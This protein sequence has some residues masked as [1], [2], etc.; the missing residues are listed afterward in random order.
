[1]IFY[2]T[3][4]LLLNFSPSAMKGEFNNQKS[5]VSVQYNSAPVNL[6]LFPRDSQ[7][8]GT[9]KIS[10]NI[11]TSGYDSL[12]LEIHSNNIMQRRQ[13]QY[14]VYNNN[15]A[16]FIFKPKIHAEL[17]EYKFIIFIKNT[18]VTDT[19]SKFD[20]VVC[21]DVYLI[22]G[23]SNSH[24]I[25]PLASY[26]NEFCRSF[27][28]NTNTTVYN[29]ADTLWGLARGYDAV[30][31]HT[32]VWGIK[33]QQLIKENYN[34][35]I[36]IIN[37]G[38]GGSTIEYNLR[39]NSNH[40]DLNTTYG[41]LLYRT[42]KAKVVY[43]VK[44]ML[45]YQGESNTDIT[46]QNYQNNFNQLYNSWK[47]D[48]PGINKFYVFQVRMGCGSTLYQQQLRNVQRTFSNIYPDVCLMATT[49]V[50]GHDGCHYNFNGYN[51]IAG[52]IF[53]LISRDFY[54]STDTANINPPAIKSAYFTSQQ[55]NR[56]A[57]VFSGNVTL[58]WG[59]D[60]SGQSLLNY[61]YFDGAYGNVNS[62]S[63]S[64]D[65]LYLNLTNPGYASKVTYLPNIYYNGTTTLY[66][67]PW[68]KNA[69][70]VGALS[71]FE[72][73]VTTYVEVKNSNTK[74]YN[75][76]LYQN[77]PNP[78]NGTTKIK[79]DIPEIKET[80]II[81]AKIIIFD[82]NGRELQVLVDKKFNPGTY[83]AFWNSTNFSSG[84]YFFKLSAGNFNSVRKMVL[85]K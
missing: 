1:M 19:L 84:I 54:N 81:H 44:A 6:Q 83:Q 79:F 2:F 51:V 85:V 63:I 50:P 10:G 32:G 34:I 43:N 30:N 64:K 25:N 21:G 47:E 56:A 12:I 48:F 3:I 17:T 4:I 75:F 35:P 28:K 23:Q 72:F 27:G 74:P 39:N 14:L 36:C 13:S 18:L 65:T 62:Y 24:P 58:N 77:Y 7:D 57:L 55:F 71:F 82:I 66:Q 11:L 46:W 26:K 59:A 31:F 37:G 69:N 22:N 60:T 73:P 70:G 29:P 40:A 61:F 33:L 53:K 80:S 78:F 41:R 49:A 15:I 52:R 68:L 5:L 8:S 45:W 20:S 67:G 9:I 16:P 42:V 38:S 76:E